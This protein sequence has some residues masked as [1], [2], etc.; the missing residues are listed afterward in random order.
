MAKE[1]D[2]KIHSNC[3]VPAFRYLKREEKNSP[4]DVVYGHTSIGAN[5]PGYFLLDS[6]Q[7]NKLKLPFYAEESSLQV[8]KFKDSSGVHQHSIFFIKNICLSR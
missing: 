1:I 8:V 6:I 2:V 7:F 5:L 4:T 3:L